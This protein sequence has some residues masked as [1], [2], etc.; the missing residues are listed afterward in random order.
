MGAVFEKSFTPDRGE[1]LDA[2]ASATTAAA[3]HGGH[4]AEV[5]HVAASAFRLYGAGTHKL[6]NLG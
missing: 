3:P 4:G 6:G 1:V 2:S 5:R